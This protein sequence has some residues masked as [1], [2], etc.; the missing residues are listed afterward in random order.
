V[1]LIVKQAT[2][3]GFTGGVVVDYPNSTKAKKLYL[4]LMCGGSAP[5]PQALEDEGVPEAAYNRR[6]VIPRRI[7][8]KMNVNVV[9]AKRL[10]LFSNSH[11][12]AKSSSKYVTYF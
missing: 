8:K 3:A 1:S 2:K 4:V 9:L 10:S 12:W 7:Y 5:L 6:S 11:L